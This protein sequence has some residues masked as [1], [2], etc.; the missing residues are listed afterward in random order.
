MTSLASCVSLFF[1]TIASSV[2]L[3]GN[4]TGRLLAKYG[5]DTPLTMRTALD[6]RDYY[7]VAGGALG[8]TALIV[9]G[10]FHRKPLADIPKWVFLGLILG[11]GAAL[12]M[13]FPI[14]GFH[15]A[16]TLPPVAT[17]LLLLLHSSIHKREL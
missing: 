3:R 7:F 4:S 16:F 2:I 9:L 17:A 13:Q 5:V 6:F 10:I 15:Y 8:W 11:S 12:S 1:W 14:A